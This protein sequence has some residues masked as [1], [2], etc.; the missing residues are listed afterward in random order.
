[1]PISLWDKILGSGGIETVPFSAN[2]PSE[3]NGMLYRTSNRVLQQS[4][5]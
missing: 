1:M 3:Y 2:E 4:V 5:E